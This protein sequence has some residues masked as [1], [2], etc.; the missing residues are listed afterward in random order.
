M[1]LVMIVTEKD[2]SLRIPIDA[3]AAPRHSSLT[4]DT[5]LQHVV[6]DICFFSRILRIAKEGGISTST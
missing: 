6:F 2:L 1:T 5:T 4:R 3:L